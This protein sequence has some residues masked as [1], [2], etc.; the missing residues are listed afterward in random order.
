MDNLVPT[1]ILQDHSPF[2]QITVSSS[3]TKIMALAELF[4]QIAVRDAHSRLVAILNQD[5]Q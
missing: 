5:T 3:P 1:G 2:T 4:L